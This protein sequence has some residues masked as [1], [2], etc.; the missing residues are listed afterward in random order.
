M[1][2]V[3]PMTTHTHQCSAI[4]CQKQI[5]LNLLMCMTHWKLVPAP[6]CR[7]VLAT[8]RSMNRDRRNLELVLAWR[9]ATAAAVAAVE[10]K[11]FRKIAEKVKAEGQ[12]FE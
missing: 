1:S 5:P 3:A 4:G 11:Q 9:A 10:K 8:W 12:L 2:A 6:V 7:D